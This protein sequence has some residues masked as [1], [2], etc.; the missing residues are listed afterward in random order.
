MSEF[1]VSCRECGIDSTS[2]LK[3]WYSVEYCGMEYWGC[4][5]HQKEVLQKFVQE[6]VVPRYR[7]A[8]WEFEFKDPF[9]IRCSDCF[10]S[11]FIEEE[12]ELIEW[13]LNDKD[14]IFCEQCFDKRI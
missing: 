9:V 10:I 14:D 4:P 13:Y 7:T 8:W 1:F 2:D 6:I 11:K 12:D 3:D 5:K